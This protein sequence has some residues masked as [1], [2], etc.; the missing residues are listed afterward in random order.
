M[1]AHSFSKAYTLTKKGERQFEKIKKSPVPQIVREAKSQ[2][3]SRED[4]AA[5]YGKKH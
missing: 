4:F 1:A 3:V 2:T 5:K